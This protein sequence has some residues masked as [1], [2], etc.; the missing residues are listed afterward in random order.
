MRGNE[1]Y[2]SSLARRFRWQ[3]S[4]LAL[5]AVRASVVGHAAGGTYVAMQVAY[6]R[7]YRESVPTYETL[8]TKRFFHG[9]TEAGF[10]VTQESKALCESFER[11][12]AGSS[13]DIRLLLLRALD[14]HVQARPPLTRHK[15]RR[16]RRMGAA[17]HGGP[18]R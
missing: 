8:M 11:P 1:G 13:D 7:V 15:A 3:W 6:H 10:V 14:A 4:C 18:T 2:E 9:R 17:P 16:R 5:L 12:G